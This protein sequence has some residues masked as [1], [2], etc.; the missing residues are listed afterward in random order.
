MDSVKKSENPKIGVLPPG[1]ISN[2]DL[3]EK[4][5]EKEYIIKKNLSLN[6]EYRGVNRE[7]WDL[8]S[9]IYGGGPPIIRE[10][11]NIYSRD[12]TKEVMG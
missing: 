4:R 12:V 8:I 6:S 11:L 2:Q 7:V 5:F 9:K 1:P 10:Q 3:F